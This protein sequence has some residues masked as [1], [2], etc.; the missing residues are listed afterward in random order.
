M[1]LISSYDEKNFDPVSSN[2]RRFVVKIILKKKKNR[3]RKKTVDW[4]ETV[5]EKFKKYEEK[6]GNRGIVLEEHF[7]S[8]KF[9]QTGEL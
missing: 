3:Y 9:S 5:Q 4:K 2:V 1:F 8:E 6:N 7:L